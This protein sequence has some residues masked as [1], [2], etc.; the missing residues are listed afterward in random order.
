MLYTS[1]SEDDRIKPISTDR[2]KVFGRNSTS[3]VTLYQSQVTRAQFEPLTRQVLHLWACLYQHIINAN[4]LCGYVGIT[5]RK[6]T[7]KLAAWVWAS[8]KEQ[9]Q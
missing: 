4:I 7:T 5:A 6:V 9:Q 3:G 2:N 1:F 8:L